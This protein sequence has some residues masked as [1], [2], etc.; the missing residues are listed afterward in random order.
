MDSKENQQVKSTKLFVSNLSY[1][2]R[3]QGLKD[4]MNEVAEVKFAKII[5]DM[6]GRS[7]GMGIVEFAS[8]E[9]AE[10]AIKETNE[11]T[12]DGRTIYVNFDKKADDKGAPRVNGGEGAKRG[13]AGPRGGRK[14]QEEMGL[15][16]RG[17][18]GPP[19]VSPD[20]D[21]PHTLPLC[22]QVGDVPPH[23]KDPLRGR[24]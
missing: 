23:G 21:L 11:T 15:S 8:I 7:K 17:H 14:T 10:K 5:Q 3:W 19:P 6:D 4:Y 2:T 9:D 18:R 16:P 12:L 20:P 13:P 22:A 1:K 24:P